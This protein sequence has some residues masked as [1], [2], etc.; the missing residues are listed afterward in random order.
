M[1]GEGEGEL[2]LEAVKVGK[3]ERWAMKGLWGWR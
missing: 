2:E 1:T 3:W